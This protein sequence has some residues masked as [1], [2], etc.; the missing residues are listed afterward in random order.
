MLVHG[1]TGAHW[2]FR[3]LLPALVDRLSVYA[4]DRRGRGESGDRGDYAIELEF[5]DVAAG[6]D[7]IAEP[8]GLLGPAEDVERVDGLVSRGAREEA[9]SHALR[10]FALTPDEL[11]Q[12]RASPTWSERVAAAHTVVR[13]IRA[14]E[15]YRLDPRALPRSDRSDAPPA[16][17]REPRLGA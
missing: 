11:E 1:A 10:T 12:I 9:L 7:S 6:V 17:L 16:R 8:T 2:S 15:D 5:D 4:V 3:F 13:E 14:E